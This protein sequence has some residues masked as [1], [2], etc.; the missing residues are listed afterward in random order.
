[1]SKLLVVAASVA[2]LALAGPGFAQSSRG[3]AA[4]AQGGNVEAGGTT[5]AGGQ[6][7]L[8]ASGSSSVRTGL[9]NA[10]STA[11]SGGSI[12]ATQGADKAR[13]PNDD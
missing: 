5:G 12:P 1:M 8:G 10:R 11:S 7:S 9:R 2:L 3:G 4:I 13:Q 6:D